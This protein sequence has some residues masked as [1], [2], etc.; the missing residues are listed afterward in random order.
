MTQ[1]ICNRL[2]L[3]RASDAALN[4][5]NHLKCSKSIIAVVA[6]AT[7]L[8]SGIAQAGFIDFATDTL[9]WNAAEDEIVSTAAWANGA[10]AFTYDVDQGVDDHAGLWKYTYTL[11]VPRKSPSHIKVEVSTSFE[12][13]NIVEPNPVPSCDVDGGWCLQIHPGDGTD[14]QP[15]PFQPEDLYGIKFDSPDN[16]VVDIR[17]FVSDREPMWGDFFAKDGV[18]GPNGSKNWV[19][20][21]N[22]GFGNPD[23]DPPIDLNN[24][25]LVNNHVLVPDTHGGRNPPEQIPEPSFL[26]L[27]GTGLLVLGFRRRRRTSWPNRG[28]GRATAISHTRRNE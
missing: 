12:L 18:D 2:G 20:A 25:V 22:A 5:A 28:S 26:A 11:S 17:S 24:F 9:T 23:T 8:A 16:T 21:Y 14:S 19:A 1:I 3:C 7:H 15:N 13:G 6:L 10:T 4:R 27:F